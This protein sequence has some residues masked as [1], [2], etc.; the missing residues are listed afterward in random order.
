MHK[1]AMAKLQPLIKWLN[2]SHSGFFF[3]KP[4]YVD[5]KLYTV[6][7][8]LES[9]GCH[10]FKKVPCLVELFE[11]VPKIGSV[12]HELNREGR[13]LLVHRPGKH[14]AFANNQ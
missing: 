6:L 12:Q 1:T 10:D 3:S 7:R 5:I 14:A 11:Q 9:S 13:L 8:H 2:E 4:T